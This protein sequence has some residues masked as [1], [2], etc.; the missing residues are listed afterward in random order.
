MA[1]QRAVCL[2]PL[3]VAMLACGPGAERRER[4]PDVLLVVVDGLRADESDRWLE[5]SGLVDWLGGE[6]GSRYERAYAPSSLG[7]Q[8]LAALFAGRLPTHG[9]G[10]GLAEAQPAEQSVTLATAMRRA[11]YR[12][13]LVSQAPWAA[14][15]GFARGFDDLQVAPELG[16][17]AAQVA[18]RALQ[19]V[20]DW[21][22]TAAPDDARP[23]FLVVHWAPAEL[24]AGP[25]ADPKRTVAESGASLA[26]LRRGL[27]ERAAFADAVVALTSGHGLERGE[28][29]GTGA[30]WTLHEEVI[31]VP[32][33]VRG[34]DPIGLAVDAPLSTLALGSALRALAATAG[35]PLAREREEPAPTLPG[36]PG[37]GTVISDLVVRERAIA[38]AVIEGDVKYLRILREVPPADRAV[39]ARG[40]EE[41]QAAMVAGAIPTPPL[42]GEPV[43][44]LLV[45]VGANGIGEA[46]LA[47][48]DHREVLS[49]LRAVLRDYQRLCEEDG[50]APPQITERLPVDLEDVESLE[51][52][53]YL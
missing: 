53:G 15:P 20:D 4:P 10:I 9:G 50:W 22:A 27:A 37:A 11:G 41:L 32:L 39:V 33:R 14:R 16:W 21:H 28:H 36:G 23:W 12:T 45:R 31:R 7:V 30:G 29:G 34:L 19:V 40:Y 46:E 18:E 1:F 6:G 26:A 13:G 51:M 25:S 5:R 43:R 49:R 35:D 42:F 38:R 48:V 17:S 44:E 47:L 52:L 24:D 2:I 3:G 8:S